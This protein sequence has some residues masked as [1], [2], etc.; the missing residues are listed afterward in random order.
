LK[1]LGLDVT[2]LRHDI[3][4]SHQGGAMILH[5]LIAMLAC[6]IHRHQEHTIA[7]LREEKPPPEKPHG[8]AGASP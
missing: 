6:W 4:F 3:T 1:N 2:A 8:K 5:V 7:Y